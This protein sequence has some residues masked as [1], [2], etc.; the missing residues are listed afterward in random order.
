MKKRRRT[1]WLFIYLM[2]LRGENFR[3]LCGSGRFLVP[4]MERGFDIQGVD[5]S[6]EISL[7]LKE[8]RRVPGDLRG[9]DKFY[10]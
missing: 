10:M 1:S 6:E 3:A 9:Y 8:K 2:L 7:A 4:F 5:M